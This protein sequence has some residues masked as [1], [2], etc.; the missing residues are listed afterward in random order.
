LDKESKSAS[1]LEAMIMQRV[2]TQADCAEVRTVAV[3]SGDLGWRV[4]SLPG[5]VEWWRSRRSTKLRMSYGLN[6]IWQLNRRF[7]QMLTAVPAQA[8]PK[9]VEVPRN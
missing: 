4:M 5:T 6:T 3:T 9:A 1:E 7:T 8:G 2:S